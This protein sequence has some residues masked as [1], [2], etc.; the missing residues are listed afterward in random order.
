M[1]ATTNTSAPLTASGAKLWQYLF[2]GMS[3]SFI[4]V[5]I[6]RFVY[7]PLIPALIGSK[8]F[9]PSDVVYLG[10]ANL[11]GYFIGALF[12]RRIAARSSNVGTI[13]FMEV[14]VAVSL[15]ACA[16]PLSVPWFFA[17]RFISGA[18][19]G[20]VMV[21]V[22]ATVLPCIS[23]EQKNLASGAIFL[24]LGLGIAAS[25]TILP[26][27]LAH[28]LQA[29]WL[30]M[31][32][33]CVILT[34]ITWTMWPPPAKMAILAFPPLSKREIDEESSG[35]NANLVYVTFALMAIGIVPVMVFI[36]DYA[37]RG[38]HQGAAMGSLY[39]LLYG[40]GA[41]IGPPLYGAVAD[42][43]TPHNA[44]R[45]LL[46]VQTAAIAALAFAHCSVVIAIAAVVA[47]TFPP[48]SVPLTLAWL[49]EIYPEDP[50][51]E[52]S[53]W[54]RATMSFAAAQAVSA[55]AYSALFAVSSS[56]QI[57]FVTGTAA[58][59]IALCLTVFFPPLFKARA[60]RE[61]PLHAV[62]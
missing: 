20:I 40:I 18:G 3:A 58:L 29:T 47:G 39:W 4:A 55:Y 28:G 1:T 15:A 21:L 50:A 52:N 54:S 59:L 45:V 10:A 8:W 61:T 24:G 35:E 41:I 46:F 14:A 56:Y 38:L 17:W 27:L 51:R 13:L 37:T 36:V 9:S 60:S 53:F 7:T 34:A 48:G 22:G 30:G 6:A 5:G 11:A 32:A 62:S 57:L 31:A 25:G 26:L 19:G 12:G 2:A 44:V 33:L 49:F 42:K 43:L 23:K 16:F